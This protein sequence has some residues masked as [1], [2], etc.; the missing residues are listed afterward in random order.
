MCDFQA[1]YSKYFLESG[2][3]PPQA[4]PLKYCI[5]ENNTA[6]EWTPTVKILG[7]PVSGGDVRGNIQVE[8][9]RIRLYRILSAHRSVQQLIQSAERFSTVAYTPTYFDSE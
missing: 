6:Y 2:L 1:K 3:T 8:N 7:T 5:P 9:V 4:S